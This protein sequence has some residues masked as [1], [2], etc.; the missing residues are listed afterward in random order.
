M[1][2]QADVIP[3]DEAGA[4]AAQQWLQLLHAQAIKDPP[5]DLFS[6]FHSTTTVM[7]C[8]QSLHTAKKPW[9]GL[10]CLRVL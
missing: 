5:K 9:T 3:F 10:L 4:A 2:V 1:A 8:S 6:L 7:S